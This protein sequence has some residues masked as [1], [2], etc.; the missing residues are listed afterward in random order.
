M[1]VLHIFLIKLGMLL[2]KPLFW[3]KNLT[4]FRI[5]HEFSLNFGE[6][7]TQFPLFKPRTKSVDA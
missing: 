5:Y 2:L 7:M 6:K 3:K 1:Y 4:Q